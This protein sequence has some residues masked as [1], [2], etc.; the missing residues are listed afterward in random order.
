MNI[1][2]GNLQRKVIDTL[3]SQGLRTVVEPT[4]GSQ[5]LKV[6]LDD[7]GTE[8]RARIYIRN[9]THGGR[10]RKEKEYR[11]QLTG[12]PPKVH[13]GSVTLLLGYFEPKD[14]YVSFDPSVHLKF[15]ASPSIQVTA[16]ALD[17]AAL[18]G[19]YRFRRRRR[20]R[21]RVSCRRRAAR[22][23][24]DGRCLR[25]SRPPRRGDV[26][27]EIGRPLRGRH[28]QVRRQ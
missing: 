22:H 23:H 11:I 13:D 17:R 2:Q 19:V 9:V 25:R 6:V 15:G 16:A 24:P 3:A 18:E 1:S 5:P 28:D 20:R 7:D 21:R 26:G 12:E 4:L 8:I 27:V 14:V 10:G